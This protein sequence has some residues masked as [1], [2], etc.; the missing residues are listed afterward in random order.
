MEEDNL[1]KLIDKDIKIAFFIEY[2]ETEASPEKLYSL[3]LEQRKI[4]REKY[5]II[6][7]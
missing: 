6:K 7:K 5:Y 3:N 2:I 1:Q 4:F